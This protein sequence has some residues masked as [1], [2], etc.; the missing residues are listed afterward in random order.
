MSVKRCYL[1]KPRFQTVLAA[2]IGRV[3]RGLREG[4]SETLSCA[5]GV[6]GASGSVF[7]GSS[8]NR[9]LRCWKGFARSSSRSPLALER[10]T[11]VRRV[12][13][14]SPAAGSRRA[15]AR[16]PRARPRSPCARPRAGT[17]PPAAAQGGSWEMDGSGAQ[18][19]SSLSRDT[20]IG[21]G[22]ESPVRLGVRFPS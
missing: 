1:G 11:R 15:G 2:P 21:V 6:P 4:G 14:G 12:E 16:D 9:R 17:A 22:T 8:E 10:E 20:A 7:G 5:Q 18:A 3:Y 19:E 13:G